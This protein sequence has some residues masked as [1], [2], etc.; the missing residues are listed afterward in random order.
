MVPR[1]CASGLRLG[2]SCLPHFVG[3]EPKAPAA[4][5]QTEAAHAVCGATAC[6]G[7]THTSKRSSGCSRSPEGHT[8]RGA[9][10]GRRPG[11]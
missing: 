1:T 8:T 4:P 3:A 10:R 5:A 2:R 11:G 7:L 9:P 6:R